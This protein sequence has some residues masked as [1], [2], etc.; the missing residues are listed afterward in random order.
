MQN[1]ARF[2]TS[3]QDLT[4]APFRTATSKIR[5]AYGS[6][7]SAAEGVEAPVTERE[8]AC[9]VL[10]QKYLRKAGVLAIEFPVL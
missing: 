4:K 2:T 9:A 10:A 1:A 6:D 5:G 7:A 3:N 8:V